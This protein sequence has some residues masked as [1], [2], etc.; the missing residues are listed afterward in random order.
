MT[1]HSQ[2]YFKNSNTD[3][4]LLREDLEVQ[5]GH[6]FS[7]CYEAR[8]RVKIHEEYLGH[9]DGTEA[10]IQEIYQNHL[11]QL[12]GT[13]KT[14][15]L[16][17]FS[18]V[19]ANGEFPLYRK[20][21]TYKKIEYKDLTGTSTFLV[22]IKVS[23]QWVFAVYHLHGLCFYEKIGELGNL[24][25]LTDD[26]NSSILKMFRE[27]A[28]GSSSISDALFDYRIA[29]LKA[30]QSNPKS[31]TKTRTTLK[32]NLVQGGYTAEAKEEVIDIGS[33]ATCPLEITCTHFK[34]AILL[35]EGQAHAVYLAYGCNKP[36]YQESIGSTGGTEKGVQR[37]L[38]NFTE[39]MRLFAHLTLEDFRAAREDLLFAKID[40]VIG[41]E[42]SFQVEFRIIGRKVYAQF[43]NITA[44]LAHLDGSHSLS[45]ICEDFKEDIQEVCK[46][47]ENLPTALDEGTMATNYVQY[48]Q[49]V[50]EHVACLR[51]LAD[52]FRNH[53]ILCKHNV[54]YPDVELKPF[55]CTWEDQ[56]EQGYK[57]FKEW[58]IPF[59]YILGG[60]LARPHYHPKMVPPVKDIVNS[61]IQLRQARQKF[62][63]IA[64]DYKCLSE[65]Q[66]Y[67][68]RW[69]LVAAKFE[70]KFYIVEPNLYEACLHLPTPEEVAADLEQ[71]ITEA[72][73]D[74]V[75]EANH[76]QEQVKPRLM[77]YLGMTLRQALYSSQA[78]GNYL[79][80]KKLYE[81][82][83]KGL[84]E[85][86]MDLHLRMR[87]FFHKKNLLRTTRLP[88]VLSADHLNF[89]STLPEKV[90]AVLQGAPIDTLNMGTHNAQ[91]VLE[92]AKLYDIN[93]AFANSLTFD[94]QLYQQSTAILRT[95]VLEL[96]PAAKSHEV[97]TRTLNPVKMTDGRYWADPRNW[98][99]ERV[100][101]QAQLV[102]RQYIEARSLAEQLP[103]IGAV[104]GN[105]GAGKSTYAP[106]QAL[107]VDHLKA[108]S[109]RVYRGE[110]NHQIHP[111]YAEVFRRFL[112]EVAY[113]KKLNYFLDSRL[114]YPA[115]LEENI[116]APARLRDVPASIQDFDV[117]LTTSLERVLKR[118]V[119]GDD[120]RPSLEA[121]VSG[122]IYLRQY[123]RQII[124]AVDNYELYYKGE[125]VAYKKEGELHI[126]N[127]EAYEECL[128]VP[129][130]EEADALA[131]PYAAAIEQHANA[132]FY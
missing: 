62:V 119:G 26:F 109:R 12:Q 2:F 85:A 96:I 103:G 73:V 18:R 4:I 95:K 39:E 25:Q 69:I 19:V 98:L 11:E 77:K 123:R 35:W 113:Q 131:A 125:R 16:N 51:T 110:R 8:T 81:E 129:T 80:A 120:P 41:E 83:I 21:Y 128:R 102:I 38:K 55:E 60:I 74:A 70:G 47:I 65:Y 56:D 82:E 43:L 108:Q 76:I 105:I 90:F 5:D 40:F 68:Y 64:Q 46:G 7:A 89:R 57:V 71:P 66:L 93:L 9:C 27:A 61:I 101:L 45:T 126:L 31:A 114:L 13:L 32:I 10:A 86:Q 67:D 63:A 37:L 33:K 49:R 84:D 118:Q 107:N 124:E 59:P 88:F 79:N 97:F 104:R 24:K 132:L 22:D 121:I 3:Q 6:L 87:A 78:Y 92:I 58:D 20:Y 99:S 30:Q 44:C 111:E 91:E 127:R 23:R 117:P 50:N 17:N 54:L 36:F 115:D 106:K 42:R 34:V 1:I 15:N 75:L 53:L 122:Y 116:L 130:R 48:V 72:F 28:K 100:G 112:H 29:Y 94:K 14:I 52:T